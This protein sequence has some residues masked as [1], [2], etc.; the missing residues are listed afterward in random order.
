M[1]V[2]DD[3]DKMIAERTKG[4]P[5][6]PK[7]LDEAMKRRETARIPYHTDNCGPLSSCR[8]SNQYI[9]EP[10]L[11]HCADH[12][13]CSVCHAIGMLQ[14]VDAEGLRVVAFVASKLAENTNGVG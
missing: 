14:Y 7:L 1:S 2:E 8:E 10:Q 13:C 4:N 12:D 11:E 5:G 3:L 6:F 9:T